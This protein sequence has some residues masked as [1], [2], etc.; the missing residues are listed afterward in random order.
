MLNL[1]SCHFGKCNDENFHFCQLTT[2][3]NFIF[4]VILIKAQLLVGFYELVATILHFVVKSKIVLSSKNIFLKLIKHA[5]EENFLCSILQKNNREGREMKL[6]L[7]RLVCE[8][9]EQARSSDGCSRIYCRYFRYSAPRYSRYFARLRV[10][11][12]TE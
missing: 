8:Q 2:S 5:Q 10:D 9:M 12:V 11:R 4:Y 7:Y 1:L 3:N 6:S